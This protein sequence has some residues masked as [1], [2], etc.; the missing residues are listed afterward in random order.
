MNTAHKDLRGFAYLLY[1]A[2]SLSLLMVMVFLPLAPAFADEIDTETQAGELVQ[3]SEISEPLPEVSQEDTS[4]VIGEGAPVTD[5]FVVEE[6]QNISESTVQSIEFENVD[7]EL[8]TSEEAA[9][10][11]SASEILEDETVENSESS[12]AGDEVTSLETSSDEGALDALPGEDVNTSVEEVIYGVDD[13]QVVDEDVQN[14]DEGEFE[15]EDAED[16]ADADDEVEVL[17]EQI[18]EVVTVNAVNDSRNEFSFS[19][20]ECTS[21]GDGTFYCVKT[22][23][24]AQVSQTDRIFSAPDKEGDR[25]IYIEK[26]AVLVTLTDNQYDDE[27]PYYD[28]VSDTAVWHRLINGRYQIISYDFDAEEEIQLTSDHYNNMHPNKFGDVLVWQGWVGNDWEIFLSRDGEVTM[29]TDNNIHDISPSVNGTHIVWQ[30]FES[31]AW[32]M[33]VYD[34]RTGV[35]DSVGDTE[36]GS[37]ENPRFVLVY[38][39]TSQ[40]GDVETRGYDLKSGEVMELGATPVDLPEELPDPDQT[41]EDRAIVT[42]VTQLKPKTEGEADDVPN[43]EGINPDPVEDATIVVDSYEEEVSSSDQASTTVGT[44]DQVID[45]I[46]IP[47]FEVDPVA[48]VDH[49]TDVIVTPY[50]EEI[51]TS[52]DTH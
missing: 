45:E 28:S 5:V 34:I 22:E 43:D 23:A 17:E 44:P 38:D 11:N 12:N 36:G 4:L 26:D 50:V 6:E 19:D 52:T 31:N 25:E 32:Q 48:S 10:Q 40:S 37:I 39:T 9:V 24:E 15:T 46:V 21:A 41:G 30:S 33:K 14:P 8:V 47:S 29:L 49:I 16:V 3:S 1:S 2:I 18:G 42:T 27:D 51:A 7:P 13:E 20:N 35:I